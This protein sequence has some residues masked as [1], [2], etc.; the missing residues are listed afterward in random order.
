MI[1]KTGYIAILA[2]PKS[3]ATSTKQLRRSFQKYL[4]SQGY[5][6]RNLTTQS[7]GHA[8]ELAKACHDD[9]QCQMVIVAGGDGTVRETVQGMVGSQKPLMIIPSGTENLLAS[10]L[11][12]GDRLSTFIQTFEESYIRPL[13]LCQINGKCFTCVSGFGFDGDVM[14]CVSQLRNGHIDYF[15]YASPLWQTFWNHKFQPI[16]V[17]LD[18]ET[19]YSDKGLVIVGNASR[20]ALGL[21]VLRHADVSDGLLDVCILKCA[22]K[23][24]LVKHYLTILFKRHTKASDVIYRQGKHVKVTSPSKKIKTQVDGDPGPPLPADIRVIP[25]AIQVMVPKE[26]KPEG[27][28]RRLMRLLG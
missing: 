16:Q 28:W 6:V 23:P 7:L 20:Y 13:D 27:E 14:N 11:G 5:D 24:H 1:P 2:N 4:C 26:F 19:I 8:S 22:Y 18:G 21:S 9:T 15:D 12:F 25:S 17:E 3:G 10:E